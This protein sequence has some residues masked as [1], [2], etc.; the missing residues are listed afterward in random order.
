MSSRKEKAAPG[1]TSTEGGNKERATFPSEA[2]SDFYSTIKR[3][4]ISR[5][6][7]EGEANALPGHEIRRILGLKDGREVT[8]LVERERR[9]GVPICASCDNRQP[10]YFLPET[11][12]ELERYIKSLEGRIREVAAT[13]DALE[14]TLC[15]WT[16]QMRL[17][18]Q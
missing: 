13:R 7:L 5:I 11:P 12:G 17:E 2:N 9:G 8:S 16:G 1:V 3:G 4:Q 18:E 6:L 15:T 10:G 14:E